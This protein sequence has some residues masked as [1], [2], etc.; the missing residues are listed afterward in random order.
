MEDDL[1]KTQELMKMEEELRRI[2]KKYYKYKTKYS[3]S[4]KVDGTEYPLSNTS[5]AIVPKKKNINI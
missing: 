2:T 5:M 1:E 3:Q 4:K